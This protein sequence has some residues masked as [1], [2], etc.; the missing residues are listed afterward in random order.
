M[1]QKN[2]KVRCLQ[3]GLLALALWIVSNTGLF[4]NKWV[5]NA[6]SALEAFA[7]DGSVPPI[8]GLVMS[9][10]TLDLTGS[11]VNLA[12]SCKWLNAGLQCKISGKLKVQNEGTQKAPSSKVR[13]YLSNDSN[14]EET[15]DTLLKEIKIGSLNAGKA[16]TISLQVNLPL[17]SS[18][19]DKF[20]IALIDADNSV[21]EADET[22]NIT[23]S[24]MIPSGAQFFP[25]TQGDAWEFQGTISE[26]GGPATSYVNT[27][28][29][30]GNKVI[31]G[32]TT[33]VF[34]ESNPANS[35]TATEEYLVK[36]SQGITYWGGSGETGFFPS[37]MLPFHEVYFPL[38]LKSTFKQSFK[39]ID[40]GEDLDGDGVHETTDVTCKTTVAVL[41]EVIVPA[42]SFPNSVRIETK[43][44]LS[45]TLSGYH[46]K[47]T[48]KA[49]QTDWFACGVGPVKRII[50]VEARI[51]GQKFSEE[52]VE[53]LT[54][55]NVGGQGKGMLH[56]AIANA[57]ATPDSDTE[58][59]GMSGI[60]SDGIHYF[61]AFD[62][63]LYSP[64]GLYGVIV[65]GSGLILNSF[66][67]SDS[68]TIY[69]GREC[70]I[71]PC[72]STA[73]AIAF[74]GNN[75]LVVFHRDGKILGIRISPSGAVLDEP[76]GFQISSGYSNWRPVVAFDG[77]NYLVV[78]DQYD[79]VLG[80][81]VLGARVT[82]GGQILDQ[83]PIYIT[84]GGNPSVAFAGVKY[85]VV[86]LESGPGLPSDVFGARITP[87]GIV[88]DPGGIPISTA[89]GDQMEPQII[90]D[91]TNYFVVWTDRR[92]DPNAQYPPRLDIFG[93]RIKPD[94]TLLDGPPDTGGI[95]I[96]I[97]PFPKTHPRVSFDGVHYFVTW[98][99]SYFYEPP[100]GIFAA[101]VSPD[102]SLV[103]G[104]PDQTGLSVSGPPLCYGCRFVHPAI[105]FNDKTYLVT[106]VKIGTTKDILGALIF[107]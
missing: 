79:N 28:M 5:K 106:W 7:E 54:G 49:T 25:F 96:N 19:S 51:A 58:T 67:I 50:L 91:G 53:E 60:G 66:L 76:P 90:F 20:V 71:W 17:G 56:T 105:L 44:T 57:V 30:T 83:V 39:G 72:K 103:D 73:P 1:S 13:F 41:E 45:V 93:A 88:L 36:D 64:P 68:I 92:N 86:W 69:P 40:L 29:I 9:S 74:D 12:Q 48:V 107:P 47:V 37:Q 84:P 10:D 99:Y 32:V 31:D 46:R 61:I 23:P 82:P 22:N 4:Q 42:G 85:F 26:N 15:N 104:P 2:N 38:Q 77:A 18:A 81:K 87:D 101:K 100:I 63:E 95:A 52:V 24:E 98:E 33:T 14:L 59:P 70:S 34:A 75:Y 62:A 3:V 8:P 80:S 43:A 78:W 11:W 6:W 16:K 97:S 21:P 35:G 65:S 55:F 89:P 102:G 94:G 27:R